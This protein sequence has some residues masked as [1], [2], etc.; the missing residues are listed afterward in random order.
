MEVENIP[1]N[2]KRPDDAEILEALSASAGLIA[3][4]ARKFNVTR[5]TLYNWLREDDNLKENLNHI[6]ESMKDLA[7]GKLLSLINENNITAIIFYLKT[8]AKDRGYSEF[9]DQF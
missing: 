6:R 9:I 8:Q 2:S 3:P 7:E 1:H 4:A 5:Q